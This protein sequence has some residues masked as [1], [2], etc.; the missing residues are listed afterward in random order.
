M[1]MED[2]TQFQKFLFQ[3]QMEDIEQFQKDLAKLFKFIIS[4]QLEVY[5]DQRNGGEI[6]GEPE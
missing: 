2:I 1:E 5:P 3:M 4:L 6:L